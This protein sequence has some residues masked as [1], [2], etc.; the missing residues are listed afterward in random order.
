MGL[1]SVEDATGEPIHTLRSK[2]ILGVAYSADGATLGTASSD[3][4]STLWDA[5]TGKQ[6]FVLRGHREDAN[7]IAFSP[8]SKRVITGSSDD[9][10]MIWDAASGKRIT[11][12]G[13]HTNNIHSVAFTPNGQRVISGEREELVMMWDASKGM[14]VRT[15]TGHS[16]EILSIVPSPDGRTMLTGSRDGTARIWDLATGRELLALSTD[17]ARKTWAVVSPE[18]FF[19]G[20]E[21]GRRA[22]GYYFPKSRGGEVDQFF[23]SGYRPGLLAEIWRGERPS[24]AKPLGQNKAPQVK[25]VAPKERN[26][27]TP[28]TTISADIT[29]QGNGIG[30]VAIENNGVRLTIPA[31]S[32]PTPDGK[33]TRYTFKD[34][35]LT[36]GQNRIH[37]R[38]D[39][40]PSR[41]SASSEWNCRPR[42]P[43]QRG[44]TYVVAV[45][46]GNDPDKGMR[47]NDPAKD[48]RALA[49]LLRTRG[50]K[51]HDRVD[52]VPVFDRD[53]T[54]A[55]IQD[56]VKDVAELTRPQDTLVVLLFGHGARVGERL[57]FNPRD[58]YTGNDRPEDALPKRGVV[59]DDVVAAM[60]TAPALNR[61]L[62]VD[63]A[64]SGDVFSGALKERSEYGLRGAVER[65]GRSHGIHALVALPATN[66]AVERSELGSGLLSHSLLDSAMGEEVNVTD[67]FQSAAER[68]TSQMLKLTGSHQDVQTSTRSKD[69]PLLSADR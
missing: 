7:C 43:G 49:K 41:E 48:A 58:F 54:R 36:P 37:V 26:S 4:T 27:N 31:K 52:V 63:M 62:V 64:A 20:S 33:S 59:V 42:V 25:L 45:G 24:P 11:P 17:G 56:T 57:Y 1:R 28:T 23:A 22:L 5:A 68:T 29:D 13:R 12:A 44:R 16:A 9:T 8:D 32:E 19:D 6:T 66:K 60:G 46:I 40:D 14:L 67:W 34:V 10:S 39:R 55:T 21:A 65:W 30:A 51:L 3:R 18:G 38:R 47:L 61:A 69:F 15:F 50:A 2:G 35:P 53:A